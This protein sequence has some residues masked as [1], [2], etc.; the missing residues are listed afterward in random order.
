MNAREKFNQAAEN[1][2]AEIIEELQKGNV[3]WKKGFTSLGAAYNYYSGRAYEGFNQ[4]YLSFRTQKKGYSSPAYLSF[5][6]AQELGGNVRKGEKSTIVI[7]WKTSSVKTGKITETGEEE[8]RPTFFPFFHYVFNLDQVEG[9]A[10]KQP[11]TPVL[12]SNNIIDNCAAIVSKMPNA[13]QI[14]HEGNQPCYSPSFD[15]I[16]M[17]L[18]G[19]FHNSENYYKILYHELIHNAA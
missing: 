1:I 15:L 7:Y 2:T 9:I 6:Q 16:R 3:V 13:P 12:R 17:P 8:T 11:E 5:R 19:Q 18:M 14:R 4:L 10:F